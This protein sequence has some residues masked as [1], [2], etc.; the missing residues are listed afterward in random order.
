[1]LLKIEYPPPTEDDPFND[2]GEGPVTILHSLNEH[3][4]PFPVVTQNGRV[5]RLG[6]EEKSEDKREGNEMLYDG[7]GEAKNEE[8][9]DIV[10]ENV[11]IVQAD[12]GGEEG[13]G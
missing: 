3:N 1:V 13:Q 7:N 4:H 5:L 10:T 11:M 12:D 6:Q 2:Y 8:K 9:S